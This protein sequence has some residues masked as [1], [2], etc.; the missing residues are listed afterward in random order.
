L[1]SGVCTITSIDPRALSLLFGKPTAERNIHTLWDRL[2]GHSQAATVSG[3]FC[4]LQYVKA[5][6][7]LVGRPKKSAYIS[8]CWVTSGPRRRRVEVHSVLPKPLDSVRRLRPVRMPIEDLRSSRGEFNLLAT[9]AVWLRFEIHHCCWLPVIR[10]IRGMARTLKRQISYKE[11]QE[12][13]LVAGVRLGARA[14]LCLLRYAAARGLSPSDSG[15]SF[16][17]ARIL[18]S[19]AVGVLDHTWLLLRR[20]SGAA[21]GIKHRPG[22]ASIMGS[23]RRPD[24]GFLEDFGGHRARN[25]LLTDG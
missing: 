1:P 8:P 22:G 24:S 3:S 2:T 12:V 17:E 23:V 11:D 19:I 7:L 5:H 13:E 9:E 21:Q 10:T 15:F 4:S 20:G 18:G 14:Y 16:L 25:V 6:N